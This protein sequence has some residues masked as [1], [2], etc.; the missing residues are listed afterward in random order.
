[1]CPFIFQIN[2]LKENERSE[3]LMFKLAFYHIEKDGMIL[4]SGGHYKQHLYFPSS[5]L[6]FFNLQ[7]IINLG[8]F[9]KSDQ[10]QSSGLT[11]VATQ[12]HRLI[13]RPLIGLI[14]APSYDHQNSWCHATP[15]WK[16]VHFLFDT[17]WY[18]LTRPLRIQSL[19]CSS[20]LVKRSEVVNRNFSSDS[21]ICASSIF[22]DA[23]FSENLSKRTFYTD[24]I[25]VANATPKC[26]FFFT[27]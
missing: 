12:F 11:S 27:N 16:R 21:K 7:E 26:Y 1:M 10:F 20:K 8:K 22:R 14:M 4:C 25:I 3:I 5:H 9:L 23:S 6:G 17:F 13:Y 24:R 2:A 19:L 15:V 18:L